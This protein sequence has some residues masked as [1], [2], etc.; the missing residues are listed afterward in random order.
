[1]H[2]WIALL[3]FVNRREVERLKKV[4]KK[5]SN[6]QPALKKSLRKLSTISAVPFS[7]CVQGIVAHESY[8]LV[9]LTERGSSMDPWARA[10]VDAGEVLG[11]TKEAGKR[12]RVS[13]RSW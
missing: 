13:G 12:S 5:E 7:I 4:S 9:K 10:E 8:S 11:R 3:R 6:E 2:S 1:M